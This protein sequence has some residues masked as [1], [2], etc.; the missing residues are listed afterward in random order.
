MQVLDLV[1]IGVGLLAIDVSLV[2]ISMTTTIL[3]PKTGRVYWAIVCVATS[4]T[5]ANGLLIILDEYSPTVTW[6]VL[7]VSW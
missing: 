1:L 7:L 2:P 6:V 5:L 3:I 4:S